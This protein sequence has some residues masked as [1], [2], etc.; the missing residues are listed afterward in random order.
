M[1]NSSF[2]KLLN[3]KLLS[4]GDIP[5]AHTH[6]HK[7]RRKHKR[8]SFRDFKKEGWEGEMS[9]TPTTPLPALEKG[10]AQKQNTS[11]EEKTALT[12]HI[13][14]PHNYPRRP[15]LRHW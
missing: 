6:T 15:C 2:V 14:P 10:R 3:Q 1:D 9:D 4:E 7:K 5:E 11:T 8:N 12:H 13:T